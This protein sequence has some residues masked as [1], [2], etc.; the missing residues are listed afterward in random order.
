[1]PQTP[2]AAAGRE[3]PGKDEDALDSF[4]AQ[5]GESGSSSGETGI[6]ERR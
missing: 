2:N 5:K 1:M 4:A 6:A 3:R